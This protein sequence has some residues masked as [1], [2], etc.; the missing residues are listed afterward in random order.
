MILRS[1][2]ARALVYYGGSL[3]VGVPLAIAMQRVGAS[4]GP[5]GAAAAAVAF[6]TVVHVVFLWFWRR[7]DE[8]ARAAHKDSF[9]WGGLAWLCMMMVGWVTLGLHEVPVP[10][11]PWGRTDPAAYVAMGFGAALTLFSVCVF[12]AWAAWWIRRR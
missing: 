3:V 9:F 12:A 7:L 10:P 1:R 5:V 11:T 2:G 6:M 8:P 4:T